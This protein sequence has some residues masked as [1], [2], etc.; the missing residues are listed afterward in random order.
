MKMK[1]KTDYALSAFDGIISLFFAYT[2]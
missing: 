2:V 1:S